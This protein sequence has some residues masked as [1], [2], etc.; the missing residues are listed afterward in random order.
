MELKDILQNTDLS[1]Q[2][3]SVGWDPK[4]IK[5]EKADIEKQKKDIADLENDLTIAEANKQ[6]AE[7][8]KNKA[9]IETYTGE[10][11]A[12][13]SEIQKA[14]VLLI[15]KERKLESYQKS[16]TTHLNYIAQLVKTHPGLQEEFDST[17]RKKF[18]GKLEGKNGL[19]ARREALAKKTEPLQLIKDAA[20]KSP[21]V[22]RIIYRIEALNAKIA[23]QSKILRDSKASNPD[24][25]KARILKDDAE[26]DLLAEKRRLL[27]QFNGKE[28][29]GKINKD[30]IDKLVSMKKLNK[31]LATAKKSLANYDEQIAKYETA[32][33]NLD[34]SKEAGNG[35]KGKGGLPA[36]KPKW[37]QFI[38]RFKNWYHKNDPAPEEKPEPTSPEDAQTFKE[39][40][41][42]DV[43]KAYTKRLEQ[44]HLRDAET[45][46]KEEAAK[47]EAEKGKGGPEL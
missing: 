2:A 45:Q 15:N 25:T 7:R 6:K 18:T 35:E 43:M 41:K 44:Q 42:Y 22:A 34:K 13:K 29:K 31:D 4:T 11:E 16:V 19:K 26:K 39:A 33:R 38:K 37:W 46:N 1:Y 9:E 10:V 17:L 23:A 20:D 27:A 40:M 36:S 14:R 8:N 47:K 21:E 5:A 24:K 30:D 12:K 3:D 32:L 28:Y